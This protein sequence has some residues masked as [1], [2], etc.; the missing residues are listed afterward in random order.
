MIKVGEYARYKGRIWQIDFVEDEIV[1]DE[2]NIKFKEELTGKIFR[3]DEIKQ[4][5]HSKNII[6]LIEE[7]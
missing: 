5:K 2:I 4:V 6:D 3:G 7:R 1:K